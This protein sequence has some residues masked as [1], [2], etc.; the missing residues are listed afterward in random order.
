MTRLF[1][2]L[3]A[4]QESDVYPFHMPGHKRNIDL[5]EGRSPY[6]I[7]ITEIHG[8]DD[9][10]HAD[11]I[12][13]EAEKRAAKIYGADETH[14]LVNG[15]TVGLLSAICGST[16]RGDKILVARNCHKS[17]YH[18]IY[19]NEL[20]PVYIYPRNVDN[21]DLNGGIFAQF[22]EKELG[23][24]KEIKTVMIVSPTYD[25]V[26]SDVETIA[27]VCHDHGAVLIVDEAHGAHFGLHP[28]FPKN[29]NQLGADIVVHS[30]HKTLPALTQT[31][32]IHMN[33]DLVDRE[34]V[35]QFLHMYQ[36]S[37]PSYVLMASMDACMDWVETDGKMVFE[38][39]VKNLGWARKKLQSLSHIRLLSM[40]EQDIGKLVLSVGNTTLTAP[41]LEK[42][43]REGYQIECE[44]VAGS[45]VLAMSTVGDTME[46]L[47]RLVEAVTAIDRSLDSE[48][49]DKGFGNTSDGQPKTTCSIGRAEDRLHGE[50]AVQGEL[51]KLSVAM[52]PYEAM[53][54]DRD[55]RQHV[56]LEA[57]VGK[58]ALEFAYLY[59]P[60]IPM[61]VPGEVVDAEVVERLIQLQKLGFTIEGL[62]QE[63]KIEVLGRG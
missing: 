14:F 23:K 44:M 17:V 35:R 51:P 32:L 53:E 31:S 15:S 36:S 61:I 7:D 29:S 27:K 46:G 19:L 6:E 55:S 41:A 62:K 5:F 50:D 42:I 2:K 40:D 60:G 57:A 11:G 26:A 37:S 10:H 52:T 16:R 48:P 59:P 43:L 12:L 13:L 38:T 49:C 25:G 34:R 47:Q 63:D 33:G 58:V 28:A 39:Y 30:L 3:I 54:T 45:Y 18:A 21:F 56:R 24:D 8:F 9:L 22:V 4:Y 20:K 1:D